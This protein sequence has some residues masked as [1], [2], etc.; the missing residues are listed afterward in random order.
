[1][2]ESLTTQLCVDVASRMNRMI[3]LKTSSSWRPWAV[4][5]LAVCST[6]EMPPISDQARAGLVRT[7]GAKGVY[8][9]EES[10]YKFTFPRTDVSVRVGRQRPVGSYCSSAS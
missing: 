1:M 6:A 5:V 7:L 8:V 9:S 3:A 4:I 2:R 10:A